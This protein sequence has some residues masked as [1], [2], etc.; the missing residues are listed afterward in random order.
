MYVHGG[1]FK[2]VHTLDGERTALGYFD[3]AVEA[4]VAYARHVQVHGRHRPRGEER[5]EGA[6][7]RVQG[8]TSSAD[9]SASA[10]SDTLA[11]MERCATILAA[12]M[13]R[14]DA[15]WFLEPVPAH[16]RGYALVVSSP[17]DYGTIEAK[18]TAGRYADAAAF[19]ADVRLVAA[20]ALAYS[21]DVDDICHMAARANLAAFEKAFDRAGLAIDSSAAADGLQLHLAKDAAMAGP[22]SSTGYDG[23]YKT[24]GGHFQAQHKW[25]S[26]GKFGT[27]VEAA[28]AYANRVTHA[29]EPGAGSGSGEPS[30]ATDGDETVCEICLDPD[31]AAS[32]LICD[33]I[34]CARGFHMACLTPPIISIPAGSW[35]CPTCAGELACAECGSREDEGSM[36]LCD[37]EGCGISIHMGCLSQ[38]LED[39][40]EGDW[41]CPKCDGA[42]T[43][44][45]GAGPCPLETHEERRASADRPPS[46]ASTRKRGQETA[47][48]YD[49]PRTRR[50]AIS[51]H[52][53][54]Y[55]TF[56]ARPR[57]SMTT[58]VYDAPRTRRFVSGAPRLHLE[59]V[60]LEWSSI[61]P[62]ANAEVSRRKRAMK[63]CG[64]PT[65]FR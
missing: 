8:A 48:E 34:G 12:L 13:R 36:L 37:G 20:N 26:I 65:C 27:A 51:T 5:V 63:V 54:S 21:P 2:A 22:N 17:M 32:M 24:R 49:A 40:P 31:D 14:K 42:S 61:S 25:S 45:D 58:G 47:G 28:V 6:G 44:S 15:S 29:T 52:H 33:A 41:L 18:L 43:A 46:A 11:Q 56:H 53:H 3:T 62:A 35:V 64:T 10:G 4:A 50:C 60:E 19:A 1:R 59:A 39:V 16:T 7:S 57:P 38:P 55:M 9:T 23:V 30:G